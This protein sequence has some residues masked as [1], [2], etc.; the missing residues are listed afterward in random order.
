[1]LGVVQG[2]PPEAEA[3]SAFRDTLATSLPIV[4][5]MALVVLLGI[6]VPQPLE[7]LLRDAAAFLEAKP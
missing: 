5:F 1:V 6:C 2:T 4:L 3:T 7:A